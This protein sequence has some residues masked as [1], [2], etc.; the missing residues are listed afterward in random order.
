MSKNL[1]FQAKQLQEKLTEHRRWLHAHPETGFE[2]A[3][4]EKYVRQQ[5]HSLGLPC[6][7]CG[8]S[9][10]VSEISNGNGKTVLL[11][12]DMDALPIREE[13][14]VE[15][16]SQNGNMH[17]CGHDM[18]TAMLLGAA[19]LLM[20]SRSALGGKV[21]LMFQPAEEILSGAKEMVS[22]HL[23]QDVDA[24]AML[25]VAV[26]TP[27]KTG[28]IIVAPPGVAA[29]A[30]AYFSITVQGIGCHGA[31]PHKGVDAL[32]AAAHI[33][34][35]LQ[36]LQA[37][38]LPAASGALLTVG[39]LSGG[40]ADNAIADSAELRGTLR[41]FEEETVAFL[42]T[43]IRSISQEIASA[44]RA[45]AEVTF[46][47]SCPTLKNDPALCSLAAESLADLLGKE[48]VLAATGLDRDSGGSED[49]AYISQRVPSVML[50]LPAGTQEA[51]YRY[52]LHHPKVTFDEAALPIG[53][54]SLA[55]FAVSYLSAP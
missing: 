54:A 6:E 17:A 45:K 27:M 43:R 49:F 41:A 48:N 47:R 51:G 11:R 1:L 35:A 37:R 16:A 15:Y 42:M 34:I 33:L 44:F 52:P 24:A 7:N 28:S 13:A 22:N 30:A 39:R 5:L 10:I 46:T 4:T 53:A 3:Q 25:H 23:L 32:S 19:E 55:Q 38:E 29:P 21:R 36:A 12:A 31:A 9:G 26:G 50:S 2:L 14:P 40:T 20:N 18:H 8:K